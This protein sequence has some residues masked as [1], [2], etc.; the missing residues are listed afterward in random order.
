MPIEHMNTALGLTFF[1]LWMLI[2]QIA[3]WNR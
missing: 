1:A 2:G 3:I